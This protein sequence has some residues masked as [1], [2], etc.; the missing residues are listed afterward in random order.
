M[1]VDVMGLGPRP[2]RAGSGGRKECTPALTSSGLGFDFWCFRRFMRA[3]GMC[4]R[5]RFQE[6]KIRVPFVRS[7]DNLADL[8]TKPLDPH[9]FFPLRDACMNVHHSLRESDGRVIPPRGGLEKRA[10]CAS[11]ALAVD[12]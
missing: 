1:N 11:G 4:P 2:A 6:R 10:T 8:F 12:G 5:G 9:T 7:Q 3:L